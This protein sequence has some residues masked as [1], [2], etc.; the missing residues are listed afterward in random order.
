MYR[1]LFILLLTI[2]STS[3]FAQSLEEKRDSLL[4]VI[5]RAKEDTTKAKTYER[6]ARL[7]LYTQPKESMNYAYRGLQLSKKTNFYKGLKECYGVLFNGHYFSGSHSDSLLMYIKLLEN[8]VKPNNNPTDMNTVF[9]SYA[10]YYGRLNQ[11]DKEIESYL[12]ALDIIR[13]HGGT[14]NEEA[15]LLCNVGIA[16]SRNAN[17]LEALEYYKAGLALIKSPIAKGNILYNIALTYDNHLDKTDTAKILFNEAYLLFEKANSYE[18]MVD[19]LIIKGEYNDLDGEFEQAN[20]FYNQA[21]TMIEE[22]DLGY[23]WISIYNAFAKHYTLQEK[24]QKAVDY[25]QKALKTVED[26]D[27]YSILNNVYR[28]LDV[29]YAGLGNYKKAYEVRGL[30]IEHKDSIS[31]TS[32]KNAVEELE[33]KYAVK[34]KEKENE[35]L[36]AEQKAN[37]RNNLIITIALLAGL[38]LA[39]GWG[40]TSFRSQRQKQRYNQQLETKNKKLQELDET[41]TRFFANISHEYKT[42]LT[43][44]MNPIRKVLSRDKLDDEDKFLI[45]SAEKNSLQL[46]DL[47]KQVLELTKFEV[48]KANY[49]PIN[50]NLH[51]ALKKTF[52]DFQSAVISRNIDFQFRFD[53]NVELVTYLD[54]FKFSTIIKNLISNALKFTPD[55]GK[56]EIE[57]T[58]NKQDIIIKVTDNG[59]GIHNADLPHIFDRYYQAKNTVTI[60][61]GGTGIGLA[62]C[63]EF[64]KIMNGQVTVNSEYGKGSQ[65]IVRIPIVTNLEAT[66]TLFEFT[67]QKSVTNLLK[68]NVHNHQLPNILLVEDNLDMQDYI[69]YILQEY[70]NVSVVSNGKVALNFLEKNYKKVQLILS[71]L[72]MPEM[73]GY[74]LIKHL[75]QTPKYATIPT[76][77]LTALHTKDDKLKALRIGI[78]DYLTKPF[79]D[80]ELITRIDNLVQNSEE[81][82]TYNVIESTE[83]EVNN[84]SKKVKSI[85]VGAKNNLPT[86]ELEWLE[87]LENLVKKHCSNSNLKVDFIA[88]EMAVSETGV[89]RK[90]KKLTGLTPKKYIDEI[91]FQIARELLENRK[92]Y[93]IKAI[94]LNVG[95]K[96]EKNFSRNFKKRFGKY[97]SAYLE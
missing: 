54:Y 61:E 7:Y 32:L 71:D 81:R 60:Q 75:K 65:F 96:D 44:I 58:T 48:N 97:P 68:P 88:N 92:N 67:E 38:L 87:T 5:E 45:K 33:T 78:D 26:Q 89:F 80:E 14:A 76:I 24:F 2:L 55:N 63:N 91:R 31:S 40:I 9:W 25:G 73:N 13:K 66:S 8:H 17:H 95:F 42:P 56:V 94:A 39:V 12:K 11:T 41:K 53:G 57:A 90:I 59:R 46:F 6:L 62:I 35:L 50:F 15:Q 86:D 49:N 36:K 22:N 18:G 23:Q 84:S 28:I 74:E 72:M 30:I 69:Q 82:K 77:M 10:I 29:A 70:Y 19:I 3:I 27:D 83:N 64:A 51:N 1:I 79:I 93:T 85:S 47:T 52:A 4:S 21:L 43:L 16:M 20:Q 37:R 34:E